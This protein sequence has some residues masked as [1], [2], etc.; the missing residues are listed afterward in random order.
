MSSNTT[1]RTP[2][3][4]NHEERIRADI[5]RRFQNGESV[6][7]ENV[8]LANTTVQDIAGLCIERMR[9][10]HQAK[11]EIQRLQKEKVNGKSVT[12][13]TQEISLKMKNAS[14][15]EE[16]NKLQ[17]TIHQVQGDNQAIT[18]TLTTQ[19]QKITQF[20]QD[21]AKLEKEVDECRSKRRNTAELMKTII[22][23]NN[24][25]QQNFDQIE[26]KYSAAATAVR[27]LKRK[28]VA[29]KKYTIGAVVVGLALG[30]CIMYVV[31][32]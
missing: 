25:L 23:D 17:K 30:G 26:S 6:D 13:A 29:V 24:V 19:K 32:R 11:E 8:T 22:K 9:K 10:Y 28:N 16:N 31:K 1:L 4:A 27:T 18:K 12:V 3:L 14:L 2:S 15:Q 20:E 5:L 7:P 21:R